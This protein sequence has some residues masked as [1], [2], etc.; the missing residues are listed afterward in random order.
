MGGSQWVNIVLITSVRLSNGRVPSQGRVEVLWDGHWGTVCDESWDDKD[1][2]VVCRQLGYSGGV[3]VDPEEFG[4]GCGQ[5]WLNDVECQ[6][7]EAT[8]AACEHPPLGV[9]DCSHEHDAGVWCS[10]YTEINH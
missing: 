8:L 4:Y 10:K 1:A 9:N 6:G 5:I 2:E 7:N 3:I